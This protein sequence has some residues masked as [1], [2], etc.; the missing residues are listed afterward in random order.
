[1]NIL[2]IG[3]WILLALS[4]GLIASG[5]YVSVAKEGKGLTR[6]L[7]FGVLLGGLSVHGLAFL[8]PYGDLLAKLYS[9][10]TQE[11]YEKA[12]AALAEG[13]IP[14][15]YETAIVS[16]A[17]DNPTAEMQAALRAAPATPELD[18]LR[19]EITKQQE[20]A[21]LVEQALESQGRLDPASVRA[22]DATTRTLVNTSLLRRSDSELSEAGFRRRD[23]R[24]RIE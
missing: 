5:I 22:L 20:T 14:P 11:N 21:T 6:L 16:F 15:Q 7:I 2:S 1:M 9:Q 12:F 4:C 8:D 24:R 17:K 3:P 18:A 19:S 10:P 13:D 23:L